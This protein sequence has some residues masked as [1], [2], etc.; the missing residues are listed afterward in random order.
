MC[1]S[2]FALLVCFLSAL[3]LPF[4]AS[5]RFFPRHVYFCHFLI[6]VCAHLLP[7][8]QLLGYV[9]H[10]LLLKKKTAGQKK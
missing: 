10:T 2:R 3:I 7:L 5:D 9:S 1:L 8:V 6:I 4:F